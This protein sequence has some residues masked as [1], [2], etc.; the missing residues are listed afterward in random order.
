MN[1]ISK[2]V[3]IAK[4]RM[5]MGRFFSVLCWSVFAG[6]LIAAIGIAIP[7]IWFIDSLT[8]VADFSRW[9]WGWVIGGTIGG[10]S[11][12]TL[13]AW[14]GRK[15]DID[16]AVLIDKRFG[17]KERLSS[18]IT[19]TADE[20][21]TK[22]GLALV[23]DA[24]DQASTI[25]VR[26]QFGFK[27]SWRAL[28][29]LIPVL[30]MLG[31][32][33]VPN[34]VMDKIADAT[35]VAPINRERVKVSVETLK[36]KLEKKIED[37]TSKGLKDALANLE[38]LEKKVDKL[39]EKSTDEEKKQA[40]VKLNDV[41]K[42]LEDRQKELGGAADLKASLKKMDKIAQGP[43]RQ[44]ADALKNGDTEAAE[45]ALKNLADKIKNGNLSETEK[46]Q[47]GEG[48]KKMADQIEKMAQQQQENKQQ[49]EEQLKQAMQEGDLQKASEIQKQLEKQ[50]QQQQMDKMKQMAQQMKDCAECMKQGGQQG[51]Q[52]KPGEQGDARQQ[53]Q[54]AARAL[55]DMAQELEDM[56]SQLQELQDMEDFSDELD[57]IKN[58]INGC[59]NPCQ[60][61]NPDGEPGNRDNAKGH[62]PGG[63]QRAIEE[64]ETGGYKAKV[65]TDLQKGQTVVTGTA[66]GANLTGR[67]ESE[68]REAVQREFDMQSDPV[69]NQV[70]PNHQ[71]EHATQY[72]EAIRE[73][74]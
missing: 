22:V 28:L 62:G 40:L 56:E 21:A 6:L 37:P 55:E 57:Q 50:P 65:K 61:R 15:S 68:V 1:E 59:P 74:G 34:A 73:G 64:D 42:E 20:A 71:R 5:T 46:K 13:L 19:L 25:D 41:R 35:E 2:Q 52:G 24:A 58:G 54:N 27:P 23:E 10:L 14:A 36:K 9:N 45:D 69:E 47:L 43:A 63:G 18:A 49:L 33:F 17:L 26:D 66:D 38:S 16:A 60:G 67:S 53:M 39:S 11:V 51:Q 12:A 31:L 8:S 32:L 29:P 48:L 30:L 4:R 70:L 44:V 7:K 72:F 3:K